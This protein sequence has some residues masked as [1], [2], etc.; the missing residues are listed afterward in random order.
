MQRA[1]RDDMQCPHCG[2]NWLP[3]QGSRAVSRS[4]AAANAYIASLPKAIV[5]TTLQVLTKRP[6]RAVGWWR[7]YESEFADGWPANVWIGTSVESQKYAP[8]LSVLERL[9]AS[10]HF[11]SAE[12][13]LESLDLT[14]WLTVR[15][16]G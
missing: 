7:K 1:Y 2:S 5:A 16:S 3:K 12:P 13:L 11:V 8:R 9:P 10:V 4:T 15:C 14:K 6:G